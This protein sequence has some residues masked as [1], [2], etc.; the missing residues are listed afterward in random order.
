MVKLAKAV[1]RPLLRGYVHL[2]AAV[3]APFALA[4]LLLIAGSPRAYVGGAVFGSGL[5]LLYATSAAYHVVRWGPR[6]R[7][8]MRRLDQSVIFV[9]IAATYT[10]FCLQ[11]FGDRWGTDLLIAVWLMAAAGVAQKL[12][13]LGAPR[14][15]DVCLYLAIGWVG[16]AAGGEIV[17]RLSIGPA[18]LMLLGG[19]LFSAGAVIY[20][21]RRPDPLPRI[22]GYHEVFHVLVV[23]GTAIFYALIAGFVLPA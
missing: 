6:L 20:A 18:L 2:C 21:L 11:V 12:T 3:L 1:E 22:F 14:W 9:F 4:G 16:I 8:L 17:A 10:P 7:R 13:W 5:I 19:L 23:A 15:L